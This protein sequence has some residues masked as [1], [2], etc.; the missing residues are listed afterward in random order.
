MISKISVLSQTLVSHQCFAEKLLIWLEKLGK[1]SKCLSCL[2]CKLF[3]SNNEIVSSLPYILSLMTLN[4]HSW[5]NLRE[6]MHL[7]IVNTV[8]MNSFWKREFAVLYANN[9]K[10]FIHSYHLTRNFTTLTTLNLTVQIFP[11]SSLTNML[12]EDCSLFQVISETLFE[13]TKI[14]TEGLKFLTFSSEKNQEYVLSK[15]ILIDLSYLLT[16]IPKE[17]TEKLRI[18][19]LKGFSLFLKLLKSL[20]SMNS[21]TRSAEK[22]IELEPEWEKSYFFLSRLQKPLSLLIEWC[23]RDQLLFTEC[24]KLMLKEG[25]LIYGFVH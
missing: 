4:L 2:S 25:K 1:Y 24:L 3:F 18:H 5:Q 14:E 17:W 6:N 8:L 10:Q 23:S 20:Q 19:F 9:Y 11:V 15:L 12:I 21:V 13:I 16:N 22:H 7:L